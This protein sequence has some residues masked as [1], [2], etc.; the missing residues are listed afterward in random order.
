MPETESSLSSFSMQSPV[1]LHKMLFHLILL[2]ESTI[3]LLT[4][5]IRTLVV[6][7]S[8]KLEANNP[9][10]VLLWQASAS[11]TGGGDINISVTHTLEISLHYADLPEKNRKEIK[12]F[13]SFFSIYWHFAKLS[14][15]VHQKKEAQINSKFTWYQLKID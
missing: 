15:K 1:I 6:N 7:I 12:I 9:S 13:H 8:T 14:I 3:D 5:F 11:E 4:I 10:F 2:L